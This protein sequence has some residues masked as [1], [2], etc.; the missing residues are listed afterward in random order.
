MK[1]CV[2][3]GTHNLAIGLL[4]VTWSVSSIIAG[5]HMG[6]P[7]HAPHKDGLSNNKSLFYNIMNIRLVRDGA[8]FK[9]NE[10]ETYD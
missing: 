2:Q 6:T 3:R 8:R 10:A 9:A 4:T 1:Y 7:L 5:Q